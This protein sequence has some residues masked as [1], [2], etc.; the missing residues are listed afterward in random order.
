MEKQSEMRREISSRYEHDKKVR[1][2][3]VNELSH[4]ITL[5]NS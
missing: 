4:K 3:A 5:I 1:V 2:V